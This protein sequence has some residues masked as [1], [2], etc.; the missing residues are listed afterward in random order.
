VLIKLEYILSF[1][2]QFEEYVH[3]IIIDSFIDIE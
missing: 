1:L 2:R 3:I